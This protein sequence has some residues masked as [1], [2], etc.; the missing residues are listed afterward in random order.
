MTDNRQ[1]TQ[2]SRDWVFTLNNYNEDDIKELK[3]LECK[4]I[5]FGKETGESGTPHLQGYVYFQNQRM[6]SQVRKLLPRGCYFAKRAAK[7]PA[8]AIAYCRKDGDVFENG[9]APATQHEKGQRG[10]E[11]AR[12]AIKKARTGDIAS[13]ENEQP[14]LFLQYGA[15]LESLFVPPNQPLGVLEHE[16]WVGP[17]GTGKS[18]L[19]WELYPDHYGKKINK[20][21]DGYKRQDVV[22][23][24]E[25]SPEARLT[26]QA[27][28]QWADHY[29]FQGEI[30]G[31]SMQG[32]RP[33]KIIV[34]SNYTIEQCFDRV[35]D[36][37]PM[38]RRFKT[39]RFP[40]DKQSARFRAALVPTQPPEPEATV[41]EEFEESWN[42]FLEDTLDLPLDLPLNLDFLDD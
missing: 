42:G 15:R 6:G 25:W 30:K 1:L 39:I 11:A 34:L 33:R 4:Y 36:R 8:D 31:G 29:P 10:M 41:L 27:L 14:G 3:D 18:R 17:T 28:K 19:L 20:W 40:E 26:A 37:N 2:R 13:I 38:L 32:L 16:W 21:W 9:D 24:E 22:A 23:I 7:S 35:E 5:I 12:W